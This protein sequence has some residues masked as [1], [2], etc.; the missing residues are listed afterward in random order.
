MPMKSDTGTAFSKCFYFSKFL[1]YTD[2]P[3]ELQLRKDKV[4]TLAKLTI[5]EI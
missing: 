3:Y 2:V 1:N 5:T 4:S